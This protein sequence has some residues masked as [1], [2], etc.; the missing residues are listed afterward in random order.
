MV[1]LPNCF[2][3]LNLFRDF[4]FMKKLGLWR[5]FYCVWRGRRGTFIYFDVF[6]SFFSGDH[7][8]LGGDTAL[9][10]QK[11]PDWGNIWWLQFLDSYLWALSILF[12]DKSFYSLSETFFLKCEGVKFLIPLSIRFRSICGSKVCL[13]KSLNSLESRSIISGTCWKFSNLDCSSFCISFFFST[14][15][16]FGD[17]RA[18]EYASIFCSHSG[19]LCLG[20]NV[21]EL[22]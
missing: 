4:L 11:L 3:M 20:M 16:I 7:A 8:L 6:G 5:V 2:M 13:K 18:L 9:F 19:C 1:P 12:A 22:P 15:L 14:A 21:M 17:L 10:F